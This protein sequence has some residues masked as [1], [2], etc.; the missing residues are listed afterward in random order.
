MVTFW[1]V[2]GPLETPVGPGKLE[3]VSVPVRGLLEI[4]KSGIGP[5]GRGGRGP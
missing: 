5:Y 4:G 2:T 3:V 1:V